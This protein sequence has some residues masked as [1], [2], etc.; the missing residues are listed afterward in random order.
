MYLIN[1]ILQYFANLTENGS[2]FSTA[3]IQNRVSYLVYA[4]IYYLIVTKG[5]QTY[6]GL[7]Y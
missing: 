5:V 2:T 7:N 3:V 4:Y 1:V 6:S